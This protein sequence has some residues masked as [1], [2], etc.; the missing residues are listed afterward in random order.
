MIVA[1]ETIYAALFAQLQTALGATFKIYSRR[2][3]D[4][5]QISPADRPALYQVETGEVASNSQKIAG[6]PLRWDM[7]VD[8]V[9]Y[10]AGDSSPNTVPSTELNGLLDAVENAL[11]NVV[12][13]LA[14]TLGGRVYTARIDGKVEV[15]ENVA[16]AMAMAVVPV[17]LVQGS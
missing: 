13:G 14:Q 8:L 7:K 6:L 4:P 15:V 16:G 9:L 3:Q 1:R 10:T 2:W 11:P 5:S 17:L 12:R